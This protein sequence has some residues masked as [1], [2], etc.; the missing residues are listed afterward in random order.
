MQVDVPSTGTSE[1]IFNEVLSTCKLIDT[2]I[3]STLEIYN[4]VRLNEN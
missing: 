2:L 1:N 3:R 4:D